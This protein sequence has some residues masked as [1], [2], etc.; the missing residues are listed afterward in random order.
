MGS[1]H[2]CLG[3]GAWRVG[4]WEESWWSSQLST[5]VD[6]DYGSR[7]REVGLPGTWRLGEP[8]V[9]KKEEY[10]HEPLGGLPW[11]VS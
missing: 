5:G 9:S 2:P 4:R 7:P 1:I 11:I 3:R 8:G 10:L 6:Y